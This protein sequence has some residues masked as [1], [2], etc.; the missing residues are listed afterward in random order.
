[1]RGQF[2]ATTALVAAA[3]F[4]ASAQGREPPRLLQ[5]PSLS[6][7]AIAFDYA[8]AIWVVPRGG[9]AAHVV[10]TGQGDNSRP[11]FS[12]DGSAMVRY[13]ATGECTRPS[14]L[15]RNVAQVLLGRGAGELL[16]QGAA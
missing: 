15:G 14:E 8:G 16:R 2:F 6:A 12:P 4:G 9:G 7:D 5:H 10:V 13:T 1:M 3:L 11:V